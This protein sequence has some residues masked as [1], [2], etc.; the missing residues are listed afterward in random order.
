[1][2]VGA[3][4]AIRPREGTT[5]YTVNGQRVTVT[6]APG[7]LAG[8]ALTVTQPATLDRAVTITVWPPG[9]DVPLVRGRYGF[10]PAG[11]QA[12]VD[13]T[14]APVPAGGLDVCLPVPAALRMAARARAVVLVRYAGQQWA[15][16]AGTADDA[17]AGQVCATGVR[18]FG[19]LA[20]G[21]A[22][23]V[24]TFGDRTV[25]AL[26]LR[27]NEAQAVELPAATGGDGM[28]RYTLEPV[29]LP[30]G[31]SYVAPPDPTATG[32]MIAGTPTAETAARAYALTATDVDG[33]A[34]TLAFTLDVVRIPVQVTETAA[35][36]VEGRPVEFTVTLSRAAAAP[37]TLHWTAGTLAVPTLNDRRVEPTE[38]FTVTLPVE[39]WIELTRDTVEGRIED[40]D[41]EQARQPRAGGR[42]AMPTGPVQSPLPLGG[43]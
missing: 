40:D 23:A 4:G 7:T 12:V 32:G 13:L 10:G 21:Y 43:G 15:P 24:P 30:A 5:T 34:A 25:G 11:T 27:V 36:A 17:D 35:S 19:P 14:V 39:T 9:A 1:M 18:A 42:S 33:D 8:I 28:I 26:A 31:L 37:L 2:E 6:Q 20:V 29:T 16:V 41:T 3:S 22:N 38:T